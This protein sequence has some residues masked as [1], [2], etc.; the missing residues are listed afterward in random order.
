MVIRFGTA[1]ASGMGFRG[2]YSLG[3]GFPPYLTADIIQCL[4]R[5]LNDVEGIDTAFAVRSERIDTVRDPS[6]TV[7]GHYPDAGELFRCQLAVKLLQHLLAMPLG[8][9][10]D[11]VGIVVDNDSDVLVT[12]P[13]TGLVDTDVDK[14]IKASGTL[15]L[16]G[17]SGRQSPSRSACIRRRYFAEGRQQ[18]NQQSGRRLL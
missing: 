8:G 11:C 18:A 6:G 16:D 3:V 14:V 7:P 4:H 2:L 17:R 1:F 5:P 9:P 15:R 12:L 13:V 10:D